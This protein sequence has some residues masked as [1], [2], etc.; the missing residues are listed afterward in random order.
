MKRKAVTLT[1]RLVDEQ[2][3]CRRRIGSQ[4]VSAGLGPVNQTASLG[5]SHSAATGRKDCCTT[6]R[7]EEDEDEDE[8]EAVNR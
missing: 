2:W 5:L 4:R 3:R 6:R 7:G 1:R 8:E